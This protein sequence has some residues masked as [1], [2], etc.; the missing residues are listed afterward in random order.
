LGEALARSFGTLPEGVTPQQCE[1]LFFAALFG[2][3]RQ[4]FETDDLRTL[5]RLAGLEDS[6][7]RML[8]EK[9]PSFDGNK[10]LCAVI[11]MELGI[12]FTPVRYYRLLTQKGARFYV[13]AGSSVLHREFIDAGGAVAALPILMGV[14]RAVDGIITNIVPLIA[15]V[16]AAGLAPEV[17][18]FIRLMEG[19]G[20]DVLASIELIGDNDTKCAEFSSVPLIRRGF[21]FRVHLTDSELARV[22]YEM[23]ENKKIFSGTF[24]YF[25]GTLLLEGISRALRVFSVKPEKGEEFVLLSNISSACE[26][27]EDILDQFLLLKEECFVGTSCN[28]DYKNELIAPHIEQISYVF[29][30]IDIQTRRF[31]LKALNASLSW[32]EMCQVLYDLPGRIKEQPKSFLVRFEPPEGFAHQEQLS[33]CIKELNRALF[34]MP[35]GRVVIFS[36]A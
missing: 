17:L 7:G 31:F 13:D 27:A 19:S 28:N 2:E 14:E 9:L 26:T 35:D 18:D 34:K 4:G 10:G 33:I 32:E 6:K 25:E 11:R 21:I 36:V 22:E 29:R 8:L 3:H 15:D 30:E 16:P 20:E 24:G 23:I 5:W 12:A 1:V